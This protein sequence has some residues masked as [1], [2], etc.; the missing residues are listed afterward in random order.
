MTTKDEI[1]DNECDASK[2]NNESAISNV[3]NA[4]TSSG[5]GNWFRSIPRRIR[6]FITKQS[7]RQSNQS[8]KQLNQTS[9]QT[10]LNAANGSMQLSSGEN[11]DAADDTNLYSS[12]DLN[13]DEEV[14]MIRA[15]S[16]MAR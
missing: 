5:N 1:S 3:S 15:C 12:L 16:Q 6:K 13:N 9:I 8:N 4:S 2:L 10:G 7:H 11:A 14:A